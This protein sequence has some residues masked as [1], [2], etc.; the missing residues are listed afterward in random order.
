MRLDH[1]VVVIRWQALDSINVIAMYGLK[2]H[3]FLELIDSVAESPI[4]VNFDE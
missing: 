3:R 1:I 2:P 4:E